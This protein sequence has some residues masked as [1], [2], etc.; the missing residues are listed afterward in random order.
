[1][2]D[3]VNAFVYRPKLVLVRRALFRVHLWIGVLA[4]RY[5]S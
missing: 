1:M 2:A 3:W 4:G 5:I